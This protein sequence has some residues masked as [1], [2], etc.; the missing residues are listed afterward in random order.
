MLIFSRSPCEYVTNEHDVLE[1][2]ALA[3]VYIPRIPGNST[4]YNAQTL[5]LAQRDMQPSII[6]HNAEK[7]QIL[8]RCFARSC[9]LA[10]RS[11]HGKTMIPSRNQ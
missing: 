5:G 2:S 8:P 1:S 3:A 11:G 6:P 10:Q 7:G 9:D 4:K